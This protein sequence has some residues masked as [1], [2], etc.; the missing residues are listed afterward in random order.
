MAEGIFR[1]LLRDRGING[2]ECESCGLSAFPGSPATEY[3]VE[4]AR[5][6][7]A[8]ISSHRSRGL[9]RYLLDEGDL[10][11]CMT[12][13]H[14]MALMPYLAEEKLMLLSEEGIPDPFMGSKEDYIQCA[15]KICDALSD[16][17]EKTG[18][19]KDE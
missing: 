1:A 17:I 16:L 10:F 2:I 9:S 13:A 5:D 12:K 14:L 3:A 6:Y 7:G 8:D 15:G 11:V 4:A 19:D 18:V